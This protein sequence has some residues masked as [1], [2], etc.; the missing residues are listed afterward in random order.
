MHLPTRRSWNWGQH[1]Q[2]F[3]S[4]GYKLPSK[5]DPEHHSKQVHEMT[6]QERREHDANYGNPYIMDATRISDGRQVMLKSVS[7]NTHPE[8]VKIALFFSSPP[9][10]GHPRNHC[11]PVLEVLRDPSDADIQILVMPLL[12]PLNTPIFDTVGEVVACFRQIFEGI[13]YMHENFV[14]HRDCGMPNILQDGTDLYPGG[15]H[16][17][18]PWLDPSFRQPSRPI[19]R[20]E[21]WP[22]YHLIDFGLS[23]QY[24]PNNGL[25]FE[26]VICGGDKSPP[27]YD[28][29]ACNPFPT[30]IYLLG[31]LLKCEFLY[32]RNQFDDFDSPV[33]EHQPW[34]FLKPLIHDMTLQD[35]SQRPTIGEVIERFDLLCCKLSRRHLRYSGQ[36]FYILDE[37][38]RWFR[39][40]KRKLRRVAPLPPYTPPPVTPLSD[41]MRAFYTQTSE[42]LVLLPAS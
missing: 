28:Y 33:F 21:C 16:P 22:R 7:T 3:E 41:E 18:K 34:L 12:A 11:I 30:D 24:N 2:F 5:F 26:D 42:P 40:F 35:A 39:Q 32:S 25:P 10:A 1:W 17:M 20:T 27:E 23:R 29:A 19:T 14:A 13:Q 8:E 15:F 31:N 4:S 38:S 37:L 36:Q 6:R 9:H